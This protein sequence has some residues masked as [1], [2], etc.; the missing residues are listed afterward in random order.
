SGYRRGRGAASGVLGDLVGLQAARADVDTPGPPAVVDADLL[1]VG[2]EAAPGGDHRVAPRVTER[3]AL[4]AAEA[5]L[6]HEAGD[7]SGA[8]P[9]RKPRRE[10]PPGVRRRR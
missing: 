8:P 2:V 9:T 3:R 6:R 1:E 7:G 5:D 10:A 4:A